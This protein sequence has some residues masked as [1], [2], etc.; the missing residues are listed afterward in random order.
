M[1]KW[2]FRVSIGDIHIWLYWTHDSASPMDYI[3]YALNLGIHILLIPRSGISA[4]A[5][6]RNSPD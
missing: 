4:L 5:K 3:S 6:S 2:H 1:K